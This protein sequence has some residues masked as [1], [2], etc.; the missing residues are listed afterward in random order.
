MGLSEQFLANGSRIMFHYTLEEGSENWDTPSRGTGDT[1]NTGS[2]GGPSAKQADSP[3]INV[4]T[5]IDSKC[6]ASAA[7]I[8]ET[9]ESAIVAVKTEKAD[10]I[11]I[12]PEVEGDA[13][14][15]NVELPK[16]GVDSVT[17]QTSADLK[18]ET[19]IAGLTI[20]AAKSGS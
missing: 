20:P 11:V 7:V 3:A 19:A 9:L 10:A 18:V 12:I 17:R 16:S 4:N 6:E 1:G 15:V 2:T 5:A 13:G 8:E 14:K